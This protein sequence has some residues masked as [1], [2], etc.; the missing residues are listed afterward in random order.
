MRKG[1]LITIN[2]SVALVLLV[3]TVVELLVY[4]SY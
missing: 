2:Q 1:P 3:A 4:P